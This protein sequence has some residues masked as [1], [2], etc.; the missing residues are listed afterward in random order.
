MT[1]Q[2][3]KDLQAELVVIGGG[4][5]GL[6]AAITAMEK[7]CHSVII[8]E[9]AG[10]P[11]GSTAMAHDIFAAESPVQKRMGVDAYK[12]ELFKIAMEWAHWS[13]INPRI[14]RAFI[15]KS[16][17]TILWLEE[18]G[19]SFELLPMFPNQVP[20]VRHAMR[21]KGAELVRMLRKNCEEMHVTILT[22]TPS[23]KILRDEK[24]NINGILAATKDGEVTIAAKSVIIATGGYG[25]N[26]EMLKKYCSYYHQDT[27][28]YDGVSGNTGDG[29]IMATEIGAAT[30]GLGHMNLHGPCVNAKSA[31]ELLNLDRNNKEGMPLKISLEIFARE[32]EVLWVNKSSRRFID[33]GYIRQAFAYGNAIAQQPDGIVYTLFDSTIAKTMEEQGLIMQTAPH[34]RPFDAFTPLPGL[35]RE[36][37]K[38]DV[39]SLKISDSWDDIARWIGVAPDV[40]KATIDEYNTAC[41]QAYDPL[42]A[43]DRRYLLPLRSA[44]YYAIRGHASVCDTMG[45]I[46][47]N[48]NMEVLDTEDNPIPGLYGA[49]VTVGGWESESYNYRLTGH[50]VGF[51]LNSG[52]IAG[53]N[54]AQYSLGRAG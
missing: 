15:D 35:Q 17:D 30:A 54:A 3:T 14:V 4:G 46:K 29:I 19:L 31:T 49:G 6:A 38:L 53:E 33:E 34:W 50:L 26:K 51:A 7:G 8:L 1:I 42:F 13:K 47:V 25:N 41:E 20:L 45:G 12:N 32:P 10:S 5:A 27:M 52:R 36:L 40:L 11:G 37:R 23:R 22:R 2:E 18:K 9:K 24:G 39:N 43:K 21:G 28:T 44:P 16:G 48:E